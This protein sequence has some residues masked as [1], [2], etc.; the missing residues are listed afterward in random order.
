MNLLQR[1][2]KPIQCLIVCLRERE[3][4]RRTAAKVEGGFWASRFAPESGCFFLGLYCEDREDNWLRPVYVNRP[5][6]PRS[7]GATSKWAFF[8][9]RE[10]VVNEKIK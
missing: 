3:R 5:I 1:T 10:R 9:E 4:E 7:L 2:E 6:L 8:I